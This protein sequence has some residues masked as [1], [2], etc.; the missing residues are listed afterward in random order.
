MR[1]MQIGAGVVSCV[2]TSSLL[3][4]WCGT[5]ALGA[6]SDV[7][8]QEPAT[9]VLPHAPR[10]VSVSFS[11]DGGRLV[12]AGRK[13][14]QVWDLK[15]HKSIGEPLVHRDD[16]VLAEFSADGTRLLT[17][18]GREA[19]VWD[20]ATGK[21]IGAPI[22][23]GATGSMIA[24]LSPDGTKVVTALHVYNGKWFRNPQPAP[25]EQAARVWEVATGKVQFELKHDWFVEA[26]LFS[27]DGNRI[28]T[29]SATLNGSAYLWDAHTGKP[30][31]KPMDDAIA[32]RGNPIAFSADSRR[33]A[34]IG[35]Y[36]AQVYDA[37]TGRELFRT[38]ATDFKHEELPITVT[39]SPD[40]GIVAVVD[41]MGNGRIYNV[42]TGKSTGPRWTDPNISVDEI[43]FSPDRRHL[44]VEATDFV[45]SFFLPRTGADLTEGIWD[46]A[47]SR[48]VAPTKSIG[49]APAA[50]SPDGKWIALDG[51]EGIVVARILAATPRADAQP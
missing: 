39:L 43:R 48:R 35:F 33:F 20:V 21:P 2:L 42:A 30:I 25:Q 9:F 4:G 5:L 40:G 51:R 46:L 19:R 49:H 47:A 27:P 38:P 23:Q 26:V 10:S 34:V 32:G 44:F 41:Q 12:G 3:C 6:D 36:H 37:A 50:F 13:K 7:P 45:S 15:T 29:I 1:A 18:T 24:A 11:R 17:A 31:G 28:G 14:V 16:V 8:G 22:S